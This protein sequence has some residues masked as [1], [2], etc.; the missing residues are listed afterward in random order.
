[1][2][3]DWQNLEGD[4]AIGHYSYVTLGYPNIEKINDPEG[5][6]RLLRADSERVRS[7]YAVSKEMIQQARAILARLDDHLLGRLVDVT[8][9][10]VDAYFRKELK[11]A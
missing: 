4:L 7:T 1:M 2:I 6:A 9:L 3:D 8:E 10:R 5:M 11:I